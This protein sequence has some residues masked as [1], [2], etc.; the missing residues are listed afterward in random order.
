MSGCVAGKDGSVEDVFC[1]TFTAGMPG[2]GE[3]LV[4]PLIEGGEDISVTEDNRRQ[5]VEAYMTF[6]LDTSVH[7]QVRLGC[8]CH[9]L[10]LVKSCTASRRGCGSEICAYQSGN[11]PAVCTLQK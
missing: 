10:P 4:V 1:Q 11:W 8:G 2:M 7:K 5:Y 9:G 6:V 3:T